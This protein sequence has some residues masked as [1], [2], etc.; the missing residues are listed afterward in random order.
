MKALGIKQLKAR[1]SEHLRAVKAGEIVLVTDRDEVV[2]ELR[3]PRE[4]TPIPESEDTL[5]T[6]RL[7]LVE[8]GRA[9]HRIRA[10]GGVSEEQ[11]ADAGR[12]LDALRRANTHPAIQLP[13]V[14]A[15][16]R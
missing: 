11:L 1:L 13:P 6:S 14:S 15:R 16:F 12:E 9:F 3:P 8:A 4:L 5:S 2:A 7:A 10:R